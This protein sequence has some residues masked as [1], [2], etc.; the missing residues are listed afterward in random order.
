MDVSALLSHCALAVL[1][2]FPFLEQ[3]SSCL[4]AFARGLL[5]VQSDLSSALLAAS[6]SSLQLGREAVLLTTLAEV[7]ATFQTHGMVSQLSEMVTVCSSCESNRMLSR[8]FPVFPELQVRPKAK[9]RKHK[10]LS[11]ILKSGSCGQ[12]G[13]ASSHRADGEVPPR[14]QPC[15][16]PL[17]LQ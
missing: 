15:P 1:D 2:A 12:L 5:V 3:A 13:P 16:H 11:Y 8:I 7:A 10:V 14:S 4:G 6:L 17:L 9:D